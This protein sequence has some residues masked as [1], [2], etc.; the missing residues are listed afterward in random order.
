MIC[1]RKIK[2]RMA[3][4]A[5]R[6][7][8]RARRGLPRLGAWRGRVPWL[9]HQKL[10][11]GLGKRSGK[12]DSQRDQ[13]AKYAAQQGKTEVLEGEPERDS[14]D[15]QCVERTSSRVVG[16]GHA[17]SNEARHY[18]ASQ[19]QGDR[20][21]A[22]ELQDR[23]NS[24]DLLYF[25]SASPVCRLDGGM[26]VRLLRPMEHKCSFLIADISVHWFSQALRMTGGLLRAR[27]RLCVPLRTR[28]DGLH[29]S[30]MRVTRVTTVKATASTTS[31]ATI[32]RK[33]TRLNSSHTVISYAVF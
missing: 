12:F 30:V 19:K 1:L 15:G 11:R 9:K 17:G 26:V 29:F 24:L 31:H 32:D 16:R 3:P 14:T 6:E 18:D 13:Q 23:K 25:R 2:S 10:P 21:P 8:N 4:G 22:K 20:D 7:R 5:S 28:L 33:S 27:R